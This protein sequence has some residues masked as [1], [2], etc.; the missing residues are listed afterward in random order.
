MVKGFI[1]AKSNLVSCK[2]YLIR[3]HH[4]TNLKDSQACAAYQQ[5]CGSLNLFYY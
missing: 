5:M 1:S 4:F 3:L 2:I